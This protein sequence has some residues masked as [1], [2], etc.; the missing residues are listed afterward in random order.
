MLNNHNYKF[1]TSHYELRIMNYTLCIIHYEL[2]IMHYELRI[3]HSLLFFLLRKIFRKRHTSLFE[4]ILEWRN[5]LHKSAE[6]V[7]SR[8]SAVFSFAGIPD[9]D[10]VDVYSLDSFHLSLDEFWELFEQEK[11]VS[12]RGITAS[13][14]YHLVVTLCLLVEYLK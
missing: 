11:G 4:E 6:E 7:G 1:H 3:I 12:L 5:A 14:L 13:R 8:T 9:G 2:R 10:L